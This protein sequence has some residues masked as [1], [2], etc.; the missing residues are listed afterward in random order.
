MPWFKF[1]FEYFEIREIKKNVLSHSFFSGMFR[2]CQ[3]AY[4]R[5]RDKVS[6]LKHNKTDAGSENKNEDS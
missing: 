6:R 3:F 4:G 2:N 5:A 1:L